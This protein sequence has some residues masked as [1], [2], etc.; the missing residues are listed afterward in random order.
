MYVCTKWSGRIHT[1]M[2][3]LCC[4]WQSDRGFS[5]PHC[6]GTHF[7]KFLQAQRYY[8]KHWEIAVWWWTPQHGQAE[9]SHHVLQGLKVVGCF[10]SHLKDTKAIDQVL[11]LFVRVQHHQWISSWSAGSHIHLQGA[12][13]TWHS[14]L[15]CTGSQGCQQGPISICH[16]FR[17]FPLSKLHHWIQD[18]TDCD[19]ILL[20]L[21]INTS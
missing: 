6:T 7:P 11:Q 10:D 1:G 18:W 14:S 15:P 9:Q 12:M 16:F 3:I 4:W 5:I 13:A 19:L 2:V 21:V 8:R 20:F 17:I